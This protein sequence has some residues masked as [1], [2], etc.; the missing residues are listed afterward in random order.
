MIAFKQQITLY[1]TLQDTVLNK[2]FVQTK[3]HGTLFLP[4][5]IKTIFVC[6]PLPA[7]NTNFQ[8]TRRYYKKRK[9]RQRWLRVCFS[10]TSNCTTIIAP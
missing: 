5:L 9:T 6:T 1:E 10:L 8:I 7:N 3:G 4:L 2:S